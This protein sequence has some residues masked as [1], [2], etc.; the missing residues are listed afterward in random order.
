MNTICRNCGKTFQ[1][2]GT[3]RKYCSIECRAAGM[4]MSR[5][6]C[7]MCGKTVNRPTARFC[8]K[9]CQAASLRGKPRTLFPK[10]CEMCGKTFQPM[11]DGGKRF[12]SRACG[13]KAT[14]LARR[15]PGGM[16][17]PKGYILVRAPE[18]PMASRA[19][20][21]MEHRLVMAEHLGRNLTP[22]EVVHHINGQK[23]DNR[24]E[25]LVVMEKSAHDR[26]PKPPQKPIT[27]PCCGTKL[28][29]SGRVRTVEVAY[30]E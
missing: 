18:H 14:G 28:K 8:S 26:I 12:C 22:R 1:G 7:E 16:V 3:R 17:D 23:S 21:V 5:P 13:S 15:K 19:G 9:E 30:D 20:Y 10:P 27:C 29:I 6:T 25:N 11:K 4:R 24:I 2:T